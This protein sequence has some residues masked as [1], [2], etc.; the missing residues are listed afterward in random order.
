MKI[1]GLAIMFIILIL[2]ISIILSAY[3]QGQITT[4]NMQSSYDSK[5]INATYDG[6]KAFQLNTHNNDTSDLANSRIAD[7]DASIN[8]FYNSLA[9]NFNMSGYGKDVLQNYV[10]AVVY[11]LYD[12]YYIYSQYN[13]VLDED[14][15]WEDNPTYKNND[16]INGLKPY[17][18]YSC[19]YRGFPYAN[20]D[21]VI[22]YSL[23]SYITI[24][25]IIKDKWVNISGYL[26]S[27][28]D[29]QD[30]NATYKY[31]GVTIQEE[32]NLEEKIHYE[33]QGR[34]IENDDG[35]ITYNWNLITKKSPIDCK[36][37]NGV[38][39]Y[40]DQVS[41]RKGVFS[42]VNNKMYKQDDV[43][44]T[45]K[46][47]QAI[48]FYK[49]ANE[50][51]NELIG[52]GL[53]GLTTEYAEDSYYS[54]G[55]KYNIFEGLDSKDG[56]IEGNNSD[57]NAHRLDVI[58]HSIESNLSVAISN[59]N[60]IS[61]ASVNFQMPKLKDYEWEKVLNNVSMI[62]FLQG[63]N[64]GGKIYNG[65]AIVPNNKTEEFVSEDSI[66]ILTSDYV[67]HRVTEEN[68]DLQNAVGIFNVNTERRMIPI[69]IN[70]DGTIE[71]D[72][73][74]P[75]NA[76]GSYDSIVYTNTNNEYAGDN[77]SQYEYV[78]KYGSDTLKRLYY[79]ALARER[80]SMYR[81]NNKFLD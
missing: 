58:K 54:S 67:Y 13:N 41:P 80:Y 65:Y 61:D 32:D 25:G 21:F 77:I 37:I 50:F 62:T 2:P 10:P 48:K 52:L 6:I 7:I 12:G 51:K 35:S 29:V 28:V 55:T 22:T 44:I 63:L 4:L 56:N 9:S 23:D 18:Y 72:Y 36:K 31:N 43:T 8:T 69:S 15:T 71:Y 27:G 45:E 42:I 20:D 17:I 46:N 74:Y 60:N 79:T 78:K 81:V 30:S 3:T 59:Y 33:E 75:I 70:D 11:T 40:K 64:I 16:E 14:D 5:L 68:M 24:Q 39:Y 53:L 1:Q 66:Y 57:F 34:K 73:Y 26:L 19:R 76:Q 49:A 47:D 38:K